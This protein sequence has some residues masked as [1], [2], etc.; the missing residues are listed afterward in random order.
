MARDLSRQ[1]DPRKDQEPGRGQ[2][3]I[4]HG[5]SGRFGAGG[6]LISP[7]LILISY[8]IEVCNAVGDTIAV[9]AVPAS[10]LEA[11]GEDFPD[12]GRFRGAKAMKHTR[13]NPLSAK[14][15]QKVS[16]MRIDTWLNQLRQEPVVSTALSAET[17]NLQEMALHLRL[18]MAFNE[19]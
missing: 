19:F 14:I 5:A 16:I 10:A 9:T 15:P 11:I 13:C 4:Y 1:N 6:G 18:E 7:F 17:F 2:N 3:G 12:T 8:S